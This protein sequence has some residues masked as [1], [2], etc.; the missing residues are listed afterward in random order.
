MGALGAYIV[1]VLFRAEFHKSISLVVVGHSVFWKVNVHCTPTSFPSAWHDSNTE[2]LLQLRNHAQDSS[3]CQTHFEART[4]LVIPQNTAGHCSATNFAEHT[5]SLRGWRKGIREEQSTVQAAA[6]GK[7]SGAEMPIS[8]MQA[9][10][11]EHQKLSLLKQI[12]KAMQ[13]NAKA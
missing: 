6:R 2:H 11:V 9:R 7:K 3:S 1:S 4:A 13:C 8:N 12:L 10:Q 5:S